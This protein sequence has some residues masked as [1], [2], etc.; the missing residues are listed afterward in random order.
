MSETVLEPMTPK[1][2]GLITFP[3]RDLVS[4]KARFL[5]PSEVEHCGGGQHQP[6]QEHQSG[7][8]NPPQPI[9]SAYVSG[10]PVA[11]RVEIPHSSRSQ[12][13]RRRP[14]FI[15]AMQTLRGDMKLLA[16]NRISLLLKFM[17]IHISHNKHLRVEQMQ[18]FCALVSDCSSDVRVRILQHSMT[19]PSLLTSLTLHGWRRS[20]LQRS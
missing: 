11:T 15:S 10:G 2:Q 14:A 1:L 20:G 8:V 13:H 12:R 4:S 7:K 5:N 9:H 3:S 17:K 16:P 6:S 18:S 19:S